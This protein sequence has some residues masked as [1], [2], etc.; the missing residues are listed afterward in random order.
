MQNTHHLTLRPI[1]W[2]GSGLDMRNWKEV[3]EYVVERL[4]VDE[5]AWI[6]HMHG[7]WQLLRSSNRISSG[8]TGE[9]ST[10]DKAM[11]ALEK[12]LGIRRR[13]GFLS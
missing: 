5:E 6:A 1:G 2:V 8:W 9:Y 13:I 4:P 3:F 12:A 10:P 11:A 7:C